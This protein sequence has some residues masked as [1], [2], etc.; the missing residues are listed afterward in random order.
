MSMAIKAQTGHVCY[1]LVDQN[2]YDL[3]KLEENHKS[4]IEYLYNNDLLV[5]AD[6]LEEAAAFLKLMLK[7]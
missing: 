3:S 2:G 4:E 7:N 1:E 5:K 6:T